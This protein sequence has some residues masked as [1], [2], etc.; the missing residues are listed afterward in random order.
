MTTEAD[1][2]PATA[3]EGWRGRVG[4]ASNMGTGILVSSMSMMG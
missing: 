3:D 1:K 2:Q 4:R